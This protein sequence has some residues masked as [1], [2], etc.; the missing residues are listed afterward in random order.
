MWNDGLM[1]RRVDLPKLVAAIA[2][3]Q[4]AGLIGSAFTFSAIPTWYATLTKPTFSPPNAIFGP[5]WTILYTLMGIAAYLVWR[6][7]AKKRAVRTAL[8]IFGIHL[9]LNALWSVIFFGLR[10]PLLAFGE[11]ILLWG[12]IIW[13]ILAFR[14]I[15]T[16]TTLWLL[17]YLAWVSFAGYL[18]FTIWLLNR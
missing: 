12:M 4:A 14:R 8:L 1:K 2:I 13:V 16:R 15:D 5:V 7:G 11:I 18:N 9:L 10:S 6:Q 3:S 17:P